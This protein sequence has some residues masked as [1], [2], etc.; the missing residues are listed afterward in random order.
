[1][2]FNS[3]QFLIFLPVVILV[4]FLLPHKVRWVWLL[5]ASYY[6]YMSWNVWLVFLILGTT[7]VSYVAGLLIARTERKGIKKLW[8][9]LTLIVCL[10]TLIFFKCLYPL[11]SIRIKRIGLHPL[12][13]VQLQISVGI[14]CPRWSS[15]G[16]GG[17]APGS[18]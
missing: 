13:A 11:M 14:G 3:L 1:M 6:A 10:G 4:Y 9:A 7:I 15:I 18:L 16:C 12:G 5:I 2:T 8:L 17:P